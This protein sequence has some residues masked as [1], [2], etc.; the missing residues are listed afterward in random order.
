MLK[1]LIA[2]LIS[3]EARSK[4]VD[5]WFRDKPLPVESELA[6]GFLGQLRNA[7]QRRNPVGGAFRTTGGTMPPFQQLLLRYLDE[8]SEAAFVSF[9]TNATS[10]LKETMGR[11]LLARG[12]Y[13]VFAEY[14]I[15]AESFLLVALLNTTAKPSFDNSL[16]LIASTS[17]DLDHLRHAA[18]IN[19]GRV[20]DADAGALLFVSERTAGVSAYFVDFVGC[21]EQARPDTQGKMLYSALQSWAQAAQFSTEERG[22]MMAKAFEHWNECRKQGRSMTLSAIANR[23]SPDSPEKLLQH[24]GSESYQ[25]EGEFPPPPPNVMKRFIRFSFNAEGIKLEFDRNEWENRISVD[26]RKKTLTIARIPEALI[27]AINADE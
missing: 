25:L 19:I 10:V 14:E 20:R 15:N 7:F 23:L 27:S 13:I 5:V 21:E 24:L 11:E 6:Q 8:R 4:L 12:G 1:R 17:L 16:N 22:E 18:R 3:K 9:S 26:R 2:H